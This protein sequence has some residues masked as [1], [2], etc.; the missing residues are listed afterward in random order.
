[1]KSTIAINTL[2]FHGY[3]LDTA[4]EEIARLTEY[5][6]PVFIAKYDP[7]LSEEYFNENNARL[8]SKRLK[9]LGLEVRSV[10]SHMD[11]GQPDS[12]A[13]FKKR[14]DFAKAIGAEIILTNAGHKSREAA[15]YNNMEE[16][17]LYAERLDLII[18]FEN[19]GDGQD[20]LLETGIQ[21]LSILD[22]IGSDRVK[23][24]YDFSNVFTYSKGIRHPGQELEVVIASL[25]HL[26]L[27]NVKAREGQWPVCG[28]GEGI[29]DYRSLF[30]R[31]PALLNVPMS[32]ELPLRFAYDARFDFILR[33]TSRLPLEHIRTVLTGSLKYLKATDSS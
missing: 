10:G 4:L 5:V 9:E 3:S 17:A 1:M 23:L 13:V 26:H 16:L 33:E 2:A 12:V 6:E 21:G 25:G 29:I 27:K 22:R 28:I 11:I 24:N 15:F 18:A 8:L 7:S 32:I 31:F 30:R 20:Q 14:M 19:P